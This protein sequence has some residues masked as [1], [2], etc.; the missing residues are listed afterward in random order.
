MLIACWSVKG[1]SGTTVVSVAIALVLARTH[2]SGVL[3]A[4]LAGDVPA[5]LGV[6][7]PRD[8]GLTGWL[9]AGPSVPADALGRLELEVGNGLALLPRG[10]GAF[11][12]A[13]EAAGRMGVLAGLLAA[14]IRP[15]VVDCGVLDPEA[16]GA[17]VAAEAT[18]SLLV[19]RACYLSLRRAM[20]APV[21]PSGIVLVS[22]PGRA[23]GRSDV[24]SVLGA[25]VRA[26][27]PVDPA[28]ARAVDAG[29]LAARM[30]RSLDRALRAVVAPLAA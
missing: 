18:H 12:P 4:D 16:A 24:E 19:T 6:A 26:E 22:E 8:P 28:I 27:I 30:P 14:D 3:L 15:V 10:T 13:G 17:R 20:A 25:P 7:D 21:R 11:R 5:A 23:M 2:H 29:A 9:S 1:G